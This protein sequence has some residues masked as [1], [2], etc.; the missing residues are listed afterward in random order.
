MESS[1]TK[2]TTAMVAVLALSAAGAL[3]ACNTVEGMGQDTSAAGRAISRSADQGKRDMHSG[4][5]GCADA[6]HQDRPG[7][8]DYHGPPVAGCP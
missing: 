2:A 5:E 4:G 1:M 8:T 6:M 3:G 7:G